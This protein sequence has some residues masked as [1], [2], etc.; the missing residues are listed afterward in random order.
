MEPENAPNAVLEPA[1]VPQVKQEPDIAPSAEIS[2]PPAASGTPH[3]YSTRSKENKTKAA[4][5]G[6]LSKSQLL[7]KRL[8]V[9]VHSRLKP[10]PF[11][12]NDL[13]V[14]EATMPG[15]AFLEEIHETRF[16]LSDEHPF[17]KRGFKYKPCRPNAAFPS[18]LYAT[19]DIPPY[20][21]R[22]SFFDRSQG[23]LF[24]D[25]W[26]LVSTHDGWRSVRTNLGVRE[27]K[28]YMEFDVVNAN[29]SHDKSHVR[30][31]IARKE[32]SLEAPVGF[33]GYGYAIRDVNGQKITLSRP[34]EFM[35]AESGGFSSGDTIGFLVDLPL[36]ER[37][38]ESLRQQLE[39]SRLSSGHGSASQ[40]QKLPK[41]RRKTGPQKPFSGLDTVDFNSFGNISRDQIPIKYKSS[42]YYEQY[43][44]TSTK[45]MEHLLN[46][47]TVF[48]E[49]AFLEQHATSAS[50]LPTIPDSR[51]VVYKNGVK[52]G[53][54]YEDLFS[55]LPFEDDADD[56][57]FCNTKQ[58][59]NTAYRNTD[60][61]S[62]AYYPMLLV[63]QKGVVGLNP[64]P[65]FKYPL[66]DEEGVKPLSDRYAENVVD[67]WYWDILDEVEAEY[68]DS[69]D[70]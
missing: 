46:P 36:L 55:F 65:N 20:S 43:E 16:Y 68:L 54:M 42:L 10:V 18:N 2:A 11:K 26:S 63:F 31:G 8:N 61:G 41:K 70:V 49:K 13:L 51:V 24:S 56:E 67:E 9:V 29:N 39:Q 6:G 64:G 37:H 25:D 52:L 44:Y 5:N 58:L 34:K 45:Q 15:R 22:P 69:F 17:N 35:G 1:V 4:A 7:Q 28:Y 23:I 50:N 48:G 53:T 30:I 62:L 47:V 57:V 59:Q 12:Q 27:G 33:D 66:K 60:D 3:H 38:R 40:E 21:V 32:A 19:T 14:N